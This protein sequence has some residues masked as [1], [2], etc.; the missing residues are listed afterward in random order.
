VDRVQREAVER[1]D[2][3]RFARDRADLA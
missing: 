1:D 3:P 2:T